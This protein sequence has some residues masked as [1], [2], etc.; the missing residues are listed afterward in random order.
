MMNVSKTVFLGLILVVFGCLPNSQ[1]REISGKAEDSNSVET[2]NSAELADVCP[3]NICGESE[4]CE[5]FTQQNSN[6][7]TAEIAFLFQLKHAAQTGTVEVFIDGVTALQ[8]AWSYIQD[9][10]A[11]RVQTGAF[12]TEKGSTIKV[13]Y[14]TTEN[15]CVGSPKNIGPG[16]LPSPPSPS[17]PPPSPSPP[18]SCNKSRTCLNKEQA[19]SIHSCSCNCPIHPCPKGSTLMLNGPNACKCLKKGKPVTG[20]PSP[21][22]IGWECNAP[23]TLDQS[24]CLCKLPAS[25]C[26]CYRLFFPLGCDVSCLKQKCRNNR[27]FCGSGHQNELAIGTTHGT[28]HGHDRLSFRCLSQTPQNYLPLFCSKVL[29]LP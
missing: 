6:Y 24:N 8:S 1:K 29:D 5:I 15:N 17:P 28:G 11:I 14:D 10:N 18:K 12:S 7:E 22:G 19:F 25:D 21:L 16:Q 2:S 13:T 9:Q 26:G 20:C 23:N 27:D 4:Y 3:E